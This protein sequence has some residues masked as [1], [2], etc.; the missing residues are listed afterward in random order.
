MIVEKGR[1]MH[2]TIRNHRISNHRFHHTFIEYELDTLIY[3]FHDLLFFKYVVTLFS[4][5]AWINV[6]NRNIHIT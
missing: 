3:V 2:T 4:R 1:R 5:N 6:P